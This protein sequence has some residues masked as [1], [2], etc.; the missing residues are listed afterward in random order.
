M[1]ISGLSYNSRKALMV[2]IGEAA[3]EEIANLISSMAAEIEEL[4]R[5]KVSVTK[6]VPGEKRDQE[7]F[8]E[9]PV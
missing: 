1:K 4:R 7:A 8:F 2:N 5:T 3:G 6:I 9:E